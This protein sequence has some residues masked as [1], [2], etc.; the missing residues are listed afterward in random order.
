MATVTYY[1]KDYLKGYTVDEN[2]TASIDNFK[3]SGYTTNYEQ[4]LRESKTTVGGINYTA[5]TNENN[6]TVDSTT[7]TPQAKKKN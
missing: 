5:P 4:A 6:S 7:L 3:S 2:D 1:R